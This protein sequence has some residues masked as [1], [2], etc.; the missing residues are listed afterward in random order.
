MEVLD[1]R[2]EEEAGGAE[3]LLVSWPGLRLGG[4]SPRP[5]LDRL[6]QFRAHKL[7]SAADTHT[8]IGPRRTMWGAHASVDIVRAEMER[9]GVARENV[10]AYGPSVRAVCALWM[11]FQ[12]GIGRIVVGGA[13]VRM[14]R[15]LRT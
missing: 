14:G 4:V 7:N 2:T 15:R 11:G 12:A 10:I 3:H 13:P 8:Y 9:L 6:A 5:T 1:Y